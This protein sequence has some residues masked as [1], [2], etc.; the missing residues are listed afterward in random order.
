MTFSPSA[1]S[2][3]TGIYAVER[4]TG[5]SCSCIFLQVAG[6]ASMV[7]VLPLPALWG[8]L[9]FACVCEGAAVSKIKNPRIGVM[10]MGMGVLAAADAKP[11]GSRRE[12]P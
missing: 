5:R 2:A 8:R 1:S 9:A 3:G 12:V 6:R 7:V 4:F 11:P 10:G